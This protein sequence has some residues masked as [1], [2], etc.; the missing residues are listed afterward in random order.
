MHIDSSGEGKLW[1]MGIIIIFFLE[2]SRCV[3]NVLSIPGSSPEDEFSGL[4]VESWRMCASADVEA[5]P[6]ECSPK[7]HLSPRVTALHACQGV[8]WG[9]VDIWLKIPGTLIAA[10]KYIEKYRNYC[11][12]TTHK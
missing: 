3:W 10:K 7:H 8:L 6:G 2:N 12:L 1:P 9:R 5:S 4:P 11:S